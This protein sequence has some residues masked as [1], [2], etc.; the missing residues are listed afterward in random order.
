MVYVKV[1]NNENRIMAV[2]SINMVAKAFDISAEI[3][4]S[5]IASEAVLYDEVTEQ[6]VHFNYIKADLYDSYAIKYAQPFYR[7][8]TA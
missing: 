8:K 6:N 5:C 2:G 3:I 7:K 4:E 1:L